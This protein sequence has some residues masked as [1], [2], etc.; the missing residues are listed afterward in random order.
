MRAL[1]LVLLAAATALLSWY[2]VADRLTPYTTNARV[3]AFVVP[4]VPQVSGYVA[5]VRVRNNSLVDT[6]DILVMIDRRPSRRAVDEAQAA[7]DLAGQDVGAS[8]ADVDAAQARLV[9]AQAALGNAKIQGDRIFALEEKGLIAVARA[10]SARAALQ[11]AEAAAAQAQADLDR[12]RS[13]L[14]LVGADNAQIRQ[15]LARLGQARLDLAFTEVRAP[16][17][18]MITDLRVETGTYAQA[19]APLMTFLS[20]DDVWLDVYLKENNLGRLQV[21]DRV[22]IAFDLLPGQ[23]IGGVVQSLG[24]GAAAGRSSAIGELPAVS[25]QTGWLRD[26]QRFPVVVTIDGY[27]EDGARGLGLR[28]NSQAD[29]MIYTAEAGGFWTML[30]RLWMRIVSVANYAY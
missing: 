2:L 8:T 27:G 17:A 16:V 25:G 26:P 9:D 12:A 23:L 22:D 5:D 18:G 1:S 3:R 20:G 6:G 29:V 24:G 13:A 14:G 4:I 15:A 11:Q 28:V 21:G 19:G 7:L 30:G 10:D